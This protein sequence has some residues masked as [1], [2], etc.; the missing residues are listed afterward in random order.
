MLIGAT[1]AEPIK[2]D[3]S[4][5]SRRTITY[6]DAVA[7]IVGNVIGSGLFVSP[8]GVYVNAGSTGTALVVWIVGGGLSA[9]G[10]A[11]YV[12]LAKIIGR[13][14][15]D[16]IYI[17]TIYGRLPGFVTFWMTVAVANPLS[18]V[19]SAITF[20]SYLTQPIFAADCP[21][22]PR[23]AV[24]LIAASAISHAAIHGPIQYDMQ[25]INNN[26][27]PDCQVSLRS[28]TV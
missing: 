26:P 23:A 7:I 21:P 19:I 15:G 24:R 4:H 9:V 22:P 28:S 3:P 10:A 20:A 16:Y 5:N 18:Q 14:G 1:R 25:I 13:S 8:R 2:R 27:A 6:Y 12:Q 17:N 11:C